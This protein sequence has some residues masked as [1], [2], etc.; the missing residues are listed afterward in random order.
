M[1][2]EHAAVKRADLTVMPGSF[3][4]LVGPIGD[5]NTTTLS[6]AVGLLRP[7]AGRSLVF[8]TDVWQEPIQA[9]R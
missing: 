3:Y 8:G 9:R 1:F 7:D 5:G 6:M 2:G 4:G